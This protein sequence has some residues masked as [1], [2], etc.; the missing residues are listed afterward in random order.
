LVKVSGQ[1]SAVSGQRSA[2]SGQRTKTSAFALAKAFL[3]SQSAYSFYYNRLE[4]YDLTKPSYLL[5]RWIV[6]N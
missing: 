5:N 4:T 3:L 2:V 6:D 1:R